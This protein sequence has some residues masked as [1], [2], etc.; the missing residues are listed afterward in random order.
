MNKIMLNKH[1]A[2]FF[3]NGYKIGKEKSDNG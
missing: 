2:E 3:E 1:N